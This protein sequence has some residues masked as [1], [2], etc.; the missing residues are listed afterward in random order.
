MPHATSTPA[1]T[2]TLPAL[3]STYDF[4]E[5]PFQNVTKR[6]AEIQNKRQQKTDLALY[7]IQFYPF[8]PK[9][10]RPVFAVTGDN[11]VIVGRI[12]ANE[13]KAVEVLRWFNDDDVETSFNSLCWTYD[14]VTC[15]PL[16]CVSGNK[17]VIKIFD[18][19]DGKLVRTL[20]GHGGPIQDLAVSPKAPQLLASAS[21]DT[22]IRIWHLGED[23]KRKPCAAILAST[24]GESCVS[25]STTVARKINEHSRSPISSNVHLFP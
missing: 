4:L 18:I 10:A 20:S 12:S 19:V 2:D 14:S 25:I 15:H 23:H 17:P 22:T 16:L 9:S 6:K 1:E 21:S 11:H 7:D 3:Y 5:Y 24:E 13:D 8:A